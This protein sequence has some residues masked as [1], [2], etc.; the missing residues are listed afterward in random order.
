V[1]KD[2]TEG[3]RESRPSLASLEEAARE[4]VRGWLQDLLEQEVTEF[5]GRGRSTRRA[6]VDAAVG[7]RNGFGRPRKLTL[8]NGTIELR[9]PRVRGIEQRFESRL[10]PLFVRR[11]PEVSDLLPELYL[12]GLATGDFDLALRGLLGEGAPISPST[13][14]RVK[15]KWQGERE[16][17][18]GRRLEDLEVV[19]LWVDGVYVK[20]GLEKERAALLVAIAGLSDGTKA[21]VAVSPGHRESTESWSGLLRDLKARGMSSPKLVIGDGHL[22]IWGGLSNV[23]P[24]ADRQ[25]CW[26]H[27]IINILDKIPTKRQPEAK[28]MLRQIPYAETLEKAKSLKGQFQ[29]WCREKGLLEAGRVLDRDW[30]DLVSFYG[31]PKDHW[32]HLR[33][34]NVIESPF[35]ALRLRT[36]AAKRFKKVENATAVIWKMLLVAERKFRRLN[37]PE[38]VREV[39]LGVRFANGERR[40]E[41]IREAVA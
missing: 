8:S 36:D 34:T 15:Q 9:R 32:Q 31:F 30:E 41:E 20:A 19:Y 40:R 12:H 3:V 5:L 16:E 1:R 6:A 2:T 18:A 33:T 28:A 23:Y 27:R 26:N 24:E 29:R 7:Y 11:T 25:R 13:V 4:K 39:Y 17:W 38:L 22:G 35:A 10:L 37:S 21:V 14:M